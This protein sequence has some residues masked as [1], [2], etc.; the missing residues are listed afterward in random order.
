MDRIE[1]ARRPAMTDLELLEMAA[2]AAGV[3]YIATAEDGAR[4]LADMTRWNPLTDDGD[5]LRLMVKLNIHVNYRENINGAWVVADHEGIDFCP[6]S[7]DGPHA[8]E[9]TRRAI[10]RAAAEIGRNMK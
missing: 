6:E 1:P 10:T 2:K 9:A 8:Q 3:K 5:A 4:L 7:L